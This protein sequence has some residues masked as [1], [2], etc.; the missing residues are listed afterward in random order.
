MSASLLSEPRLARDGVQ[1]GDEYT[2]DD[3]RGVVGLRSGESS[4]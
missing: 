3:E 2:Y 4:C 1:T